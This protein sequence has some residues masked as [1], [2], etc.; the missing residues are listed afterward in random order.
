MRTG[1]AT[2]DVPI[3]VPVQ[4]LL[5]VCCTC[6]QVYAAICM[7]P[8]HKYNYCGILARGF[9]I[10]AEIARNPNSSRNPWLK[11]ARANALVGFYASLAVRRPLRY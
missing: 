8:A 1:R 6:T 10:N 3:P 11:N 2:V 5:I 9:T 7:P 4:C